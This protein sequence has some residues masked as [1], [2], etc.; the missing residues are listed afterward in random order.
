MKLKTFS[1]NPFEMNCYV[2][3]DEKSGDGVIIDPG[4]YT[5]VEKEEILDYIRT[6]NI[7]IKYIINSHGHIDHIMGN[8]W[9][10]GQFNVPLLMHEN[11]MPLINS[12]LE[13]ANMFGIAFP[14]PPAPDKFLCEN[15]TIQFGDCMLTVLHTPGH[16]PG[17]VCLVDEKEK[18]ILAGD[19]VFHGSIGRTDLWMGDMEVLLDSIK[20][21]II[22]YADDFVLYPGHY[23]KTTI[24][25]EKNFNPFLK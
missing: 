14:Q 12:A 21:K 16:S 1:V 15:D 23:E 9:A 6:N 18:L 24:G 8:K 2:Y 19:C 5:H 3:H 25:E 22:N 20:N 13:Q 4:A 10:K 11:D 17:S 7:T